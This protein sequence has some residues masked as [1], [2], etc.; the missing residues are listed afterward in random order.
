[1]SEL[2]EK[3]E[4][5]IHDIAP[6]L[7]PTISG[8]LQVRIIGIIKGVAELELRIVD[9]DNSQRCLKSF[10][11]AKVHVGRTMTL[12]GMDVNINFVR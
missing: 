10:G 3:R 11:S 5:I 1:M 8:H 6:T 2:S 9:Q 4:F 7:C 12:R